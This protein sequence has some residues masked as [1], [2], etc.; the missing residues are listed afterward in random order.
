MIK[1]NFIIVGLMILTSCNTEPK[2]NNSLPLIDVEEISLEQEAKSTSIKVIDT[3]FSKG[4]LI[5]QQEITLWDEQKMH[6]HLCDGLVVGFLGLRE[7]LYQ[8]YPDSIVDRTNTRIVSKGS[9]C[10]T[11]VAVYVSG[12]RYQFNTFYVSNDIP[13]FY[14]IQR[15]D[16]GRTVSVNINEGVKPA[17]IDELGAKA[18]QGE[19]PACELDNLKQMEDD[20]SEKLLSTNPKDNFTVTELDSFQWE[21]ILK[22]DFT[23]TDILNKNAKRCE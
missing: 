13:G 12:G 2:E 21:P 22:N 4:R 17:V 11:D 10:L 5:N 9:P 18:I 7:G 1:W 16:N 3:D 19:L 6:G 14:V 23:K 8:L 15:I 20:F